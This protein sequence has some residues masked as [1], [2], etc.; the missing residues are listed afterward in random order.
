MHSTHTGYVRMDVRRDVEGDPQYNYRVFDQAQYDGSQFVNTENGSRLTYNPYCWDKVSFEVPGKEQPT[1]SDNLETHTC[2]AVIPVLKTSEPIK[3]LC[4]DLDLGVLMN[5]P[6]VKITQYLFTGIK[7]DEKDDFVDQEHI[8]LVEYAGLKYMYFSS[9][10]FRP[11]TR[12]NFYPFDS[13][14]SFKESY[15]ENYTKIKLTKIYTR[16]YK[17]GK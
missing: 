12:L 17:K 10:G 7:R 5:L 11:T 9:G 13:L 14:E 8:Y 16:T 3:C 2:E 6:K 4:D 1:Y 15:E